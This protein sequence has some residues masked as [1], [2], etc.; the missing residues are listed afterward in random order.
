MKYQF[1]VEGMSCAVCSAAV[2]KVVSRHAGVLRASV[3]LVEKTLFCECEKEVRPEDVIAWVESAGFS[4]TLKTPEKKQKTG[5]ARELI[6]FFVS[7][8]C[9]LS[10]LYLSMG[11]MFSW[12][13]PATRIS[14]VLQAVLCAAVFVLNR[15]FFVRGVQAVARKSPNMDTLVSLGA[16]CAFLYSALESGLFL[17]G[18]KE[19]LGHLYF[20]SGAMIFTLVTLGKFLEERAK[21]KTGV[22]LRSLT[23]LSPNTV[24]VLRAE[25]ACEIP[26][27]TLCIGDLVVV[28]PGERIAVDGTVV[29]G[30]SAL[31][32]SALTGES[33]PRDV[34]VGDAVLSGSIN[35]TGALTLRAEKKVSESTLSQMIAL[36]EEAGVSRAPVARLADRVAGVFVPCV[37][38]IAALT[39]VLWLLGGASAAFAVG[40][41]ISVLVVSC[42]CALGLA[43]PVAIT[44]ALGQCASRGVL[45]R[46][47]SLFDRLVLCDTVLFDKTGTLTVGAPS[48]SRV[49]PLIEEAEF[50]F[51][52]SALERQSTHPLARAVCRFAGEVT[53]EVTAFREVFGRGAEACL[54]GCVLRA[55]NAAFM[56][57]NGVDVSVLPEAAFA[58][59]TE[60]VALLYFARD[61]TCIGAIALFDQPKE[62]SPV[63]VRELKALSLKVGMLT[64]DSESPSKSVFKACDLDFFSFGLLPQE[65]EG[66]L[67]R[68]QESGHCVAMVGDGIND[69][70][71]LSRADVGISV[72]SGTDL[73]QNSADVILLYNDLTEV[74][75][76]IRYARRVRRIIKEN[77]F[78]AFFYNVW[79]IPFAAGIFGLAPNPMVSA[80]SMS[81]SSLFV[82]CN[83]LR[84]YRGKEKQ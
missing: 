30:E 26:A 54:D 61:L 71:S 23:E 5:A 57:E 78:W 65:K 35:L 60:G 20:E 74:P 29:V 50:L 38:V 75:R 36:L 22:A 14:V 66:E 7:L 21:Q 10:L 81:L 6:R 12:P 58:A 73:A 9:L 72:G 39:A 76:L 40:R 8:L 83:A 63:A 43:T 41:A 53:A 82:V 62:Q 64:G 18:I 68:L 47:A 48:V 15:H 55:G 11:Q 4:A 42:P 67:S 79:M 49:F 44:A 25:Q 17:F 37:S 1:L 59:E 13:Q 77:L 69:A 31:D 56:Q 33:L 51:L 3:N 46:D 32:T 16:G 27:E 19:T 34:S 28:L 52:A 24:R 84:L 70:L 45:V 2:E 80:A